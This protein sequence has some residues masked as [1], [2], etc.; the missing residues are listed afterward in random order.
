[1]V[2]EYFLFFRSGDA[3]RLF[4]LTKLADDDDDDDDGNNRQA[5]TKQNNDLKEAKGEL[6]TETDM[7][8]SKCFT[9]REVLKGQHLFLV[10]ISCV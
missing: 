7:K 10:H 6:S 2:V 4:V 8:V 1:M 3:Q 5:F 9:E